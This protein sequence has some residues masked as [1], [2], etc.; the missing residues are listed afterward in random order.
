[1]GFIKLFMNSKY[2]LLESIKVV[3]QTHSHMRAISIV[4]IKQQH[5]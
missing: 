3:S 1:M 2:N 5:V 4:V